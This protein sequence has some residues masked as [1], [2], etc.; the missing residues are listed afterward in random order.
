M[1]ETLHRKTR[2]G[3]IVSDKMDKTVVVMI[4]KKVMHPVYKKFITRRTKYKAHDEL[5]AFQM[6]DVVEIEETRP[7][8]RYKRWRVKR[9]IERIA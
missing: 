8:S 1:S 5:N 6:D 3:R 7:L 4:E 9:L 2:T